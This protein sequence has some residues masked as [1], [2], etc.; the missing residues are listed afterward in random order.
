MIDMQSNVN[1][2]ARDIYKQKLDKEFKS[3]NR[4]TISRYSDKELATW[5]SEYPPDSPQFILAEHEWQRRLMADQIR[6]S[7]FAAYI[8]IIGTIIGAITT[9]LITKWP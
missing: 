9:W 8:G 7:R 5:Q 3:I 4:R 6:G 1:R 2:A